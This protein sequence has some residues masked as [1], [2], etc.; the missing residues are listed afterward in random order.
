VRS[1]NGLV[2]IR[3]QLMPTVTAF[4][5]EQ[6]EQ[7]AL[8]NLSFSESVTGLAASDFQITAEGCEIGEILGDGQSYE[9]WLI[10]CGHGLISLTLAAN[11]VQG[12]TTGPASSAVAELDFDREPPEVSWLED[13][14][15]LSTTLEFK[16]NYSA[17]ATLPSAEQFQVSGCD[18]FEV[19]SAT[20]HILLTASGC[21]EGLVSV[22][23]AANSFAD[24]HSNL[25]P[26][27]ALITQRT[28]DLTDPEPIWSVSEVD[29]DSDG[30]HFVVTLEFS[31]PVSYESSTDL[32]SAVESSC[33]VTLESHPE[34]IS[35]QFQACEPGEQ[36]LLLAA[37]TL[38]DA[39]GRSG[40]AAD[41]IFSVRVN[42]PTPVLAPAEPEPAPE[43]APELEP[44]PA[45]DPERGAP[46]QSPAVE[47]T[48]GA[49][50][51]AATAPVTSPP[52][53]EPAPTNGAATEPGAG[54]Q[55]EVNPGPAAAP[56]AVNQAS[57][58]LVE[59]EVGSAES[60]RTAGTGP[61]NS[62][63]SDEPASGEL[64]LASDLNL[65][66]QI[67][68]RAA[69]VANAELWLLA[70]SALG[71]S[72]AGLSLWAWRRRGG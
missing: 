72:L 30:A 23:L 58:E 38:T 71:A 67:R 70:A 18:A 60:E 4:S 55:A 62:T 3:Y 47:P 15:A 61:G 51:P 7:A 56:I 14:Y 21:E 39:A 45:T 1:G 17:A 40:P 33:S 29:F 53:S 26:S 5:G 68:G 50:P 12:G 10:G 36:Q 6:R 35:I 66:T 42:Q 65:A 13:A 59:T 44:A 57:T 20:D 63:F 25:S 48:P 9:V 34:Q 11:S 69:R 16:L 52:A 46:T 24:E 19:S 27:A 64:V 28:V 49:A 22:E 54:G 32:V 41:S 2:I 37:G 31:E 43:P 8:F